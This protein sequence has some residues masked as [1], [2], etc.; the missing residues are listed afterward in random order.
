MASG[1]VPDVDPVAEGND[2][3]FLAVIDRNGGRRARAPGC[4]PTEM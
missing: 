4:W 3:D 2:G 1:V